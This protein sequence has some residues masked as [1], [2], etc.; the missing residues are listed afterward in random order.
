[1]RLLQLQT[2]VAVAEAGSIRAAAREMGRTQPSLTKSLHQLEEELGCPVF[3]RTQRGVIL[4]KIGESVLAE[5][6]SVVV[7]VDRIK[8]GVQQRLENMA[9]EIRVCVS[10]IGGLLLLPQA[11]NDLQ[12]KYPLVKVVVE[13]GLYPLA[14]S[15][16]REG[17]YDLVLGPEPPDSVGVELKVEPLL[18]TELMIVAR[19][20][21]PQRES[22]SLKELL[23]Y[24]W[25]V[26]GAPGS[27]SSLYTVAF[28]GA[29]MKVPEAVIH[30]NSLYS[31]VAMLE[32]TEGLCVLPRRLSEFILGR[33]NLVELKVKERL[34]KLSI[35][36]FTRANVPLTSV[37][38]ELARWV[39]LIAA[40]YRK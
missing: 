13:E 8:S 31:V 6:R 22:R 24:P 26:N 28:E 18:V 5:A 20:G 10:P 32:Q 12:R 17:Y 15:P 21:H 16:L 14:L 27:P 1:M 34:P 4:T 11:I 23:G 40:R 19:E 39:R 29:G 25:I 3:Q 33:N 2:L 36:M 38:E 35:A 30:C 37:T 7:Q 9:G